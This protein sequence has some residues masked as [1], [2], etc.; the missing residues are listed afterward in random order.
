MEKLV[1]TFYG[2]YHSNSTV[3]KSLKNAYLHLASWS[4]TATWMKNG[5]WLTC[6]FKEKANSSFAILVYFFLTDHKLIDYFD[7]GIKEQEER[8]TKKQLSILHSA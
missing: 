2:E 1:W 8:T 5:M 6:N 3:A 7:E 4:V